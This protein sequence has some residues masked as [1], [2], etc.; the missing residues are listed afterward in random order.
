MGACGPTWGVWR[1]LLNAFHSHCMQLQ[2][3]LG[4]SLYAATLPMV[5]PRS[6]AAGMGR[7]DGEAE[8][9]NKCRELGWDAR[10][11]EIVEAMDQSVINAGNDAGS[12]FGIEGFSSEQFAAREPRT[13]RVLQLLCRTIAACVTGAYL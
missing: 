10:Q 11:V 2:P 8:P 7:V 3:V 4:L 13:P 12:F 6:H 5:V 9:P 1:E